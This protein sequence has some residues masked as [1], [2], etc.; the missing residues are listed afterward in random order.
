MLEHHLALPRRAGEHDHVDPV[1]CK[2]HAGGGAPVV[3]QHGGPLRDHGLLVVVLG[4]GP[5]HGGE[6][7]PDALGARLMVK[8][9]PAKGLGQGDLGQVIAGGAEAAG[10]DENIRPFFGDVHRLPHPVGVVPH[11][12]VVK[13]VDAQL[14]KALGDH[15][16]V[17][18]G[19]VAQQ[20]LCPDG[21]EFCGVAHGV[22]T[23]LSMPSTA[24]CTSASM[25]SAASASWISSRV[26][27]VFGWRGVK[28]VQQSS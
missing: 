19:D 4:D 26:G 11:D 16:R 18:V 22:S 13:D 3:V 14:G 25:S 17:G 10:G 15:L 27:R 8:E 1:G 12:G 9:L 28:T 21:N 24:F 7:V 6:A 23:T 5:A 20:Q 2:G